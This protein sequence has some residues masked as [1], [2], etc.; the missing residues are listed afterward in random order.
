MGHEFT[1]GGATLTA[2]PSGALFWRARGLLVVSDLHLGK[3]ARLAR[4]GG[5]LIPPY[6]TRETLEKLDRDLAA[7]A[8]RAVM[9]LGDS[10]DGPEAADDLDPTDAARLRGLMEGRDWT[11]VSGNHDP[12]PP[13]AFGAE[14]AEVILDG[15]N[16][17]HIGGAAT[18]E[19]SGH[20][21][22][23]ARL[24]GRS[25]PCFALTENRLILPAFGAYTGGLWADDPTVARLLAGPAQ[26]MLTGTRIRVIP[27]PAV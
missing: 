3:S 7:T 22:P 4:R 1:F 10:F 8:A 17:R 16:F 11:W 27:L 14:T 12:G 21:H 26:A 18:P 15:L 9:A 13:G 20:L 6:E 19:I 5:A 25:H 2:L 23:K 24:A